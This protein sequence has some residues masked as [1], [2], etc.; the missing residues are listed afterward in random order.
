MKKTK[1][2]L[3]IFSSAIIAGSPIVQRVEA[4]E[5]SGGNNLLKYGGFER[6]KAYAS[7]FADFSQAKPFYGWDCVGDWFEHVFVGREAIEGNA[8]VVI[9]SPCWITRGVKVKPGVEYQING[10]VRTALPSLPVKTGLGAYFEVKA[11]KA[12]LVRRSISGM[13]D[14]TRLSG[15]FKVP[16]GFDNVRINIGVKTAL[17]TAFFDGFEITRVEKNK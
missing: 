3:V 1:F 4:S 7:P 11:G 14:W 16:A 9:T 13:R 8:C 2:V 10:Y 12:I 17:G 15:N 6:L 5:P